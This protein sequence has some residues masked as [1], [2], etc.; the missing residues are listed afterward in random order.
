M[1]AYP[2]A[3]SMR[4][5]SMLYDQGFASHPA[6]GIIRARLRKERGRERG[7]TKP[8][9]GYNAWANKEEIVADFQAGA[10]PIEDRK[11][12]GPQAEAAPEEAAPAE[13]APAEAA[14]EEAAPAAPEEAVTAEA[15]P[16]VQEAGADAADEQIVAVQA[17]PWGR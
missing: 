16:E 2:F 6:P 12:E 13:A 15:A 1:R 3:T 5:F 14:P 10:I 8:A 7:K 4:S 9:G 17:R 11:P